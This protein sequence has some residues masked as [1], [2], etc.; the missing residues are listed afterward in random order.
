MGCYEGLQCVGGAGQCGGVAETKERSRRWNGFVC[1]DCRYVF[2]MPRDHDGRGAVCP[3]CRRLLRIPGV[4]DSPGPLVSPLV[5]GGEQ[6][7]E[8]GVGESE[9][10]QVRRRRKRRGGKVDRPAWESAPGREETSGKRDKWQM[11]WMLVGGAVLLFVI[12]VVAVVIFRGG[13]RPVPEKVLVAENEAAVEVVAETVAEVPGK[14]Q[15]SDAEFLEEAEPLARQFL[16]ATTVDEVLRLVREPGRAEARLRKFHPDGKIEAPGMAGFNIYADVLRDGPGISVRVQTRD[17]MEKSLVFFETAEGLR[18]DW[19][20][21]AA[22]SEMSWEEFLKE[23]PVVG[24][25]FR[26]LLSPRDYYNFEF[27]DDQKWQSY[28]L[29]SADGEHAV[30]GYSERGTVTHSQLRMPPDSKQAPM[31]VLLKFPE[32]G[33]ARDQVM[34]DRVIAEG[35]VLETETPP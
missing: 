25:V 34:I 3:S 5:V 16:E 13:E 24:K 21:W 6:R 18:I 17:Y 8:S 26:V 31:M 4:G 29:E 30:Y 12:L 32:T 35:W 33:T 7:E 23:K 20:S 28:R 22:W 14:G 15:R 9:P 2:R 1:P 11:L 27:A 19:E 10:K